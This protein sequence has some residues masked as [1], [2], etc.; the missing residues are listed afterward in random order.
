MAA[1]HRSR[2]A[3]ITTCSRTA[4]MLLCCQANLTWLCVTRRAVWPVYKN[5]VFT[6]RCPVCRF[7]APN[8]LFTVET[9]QSM[10][11]KGRS[12][13]HDKT[14]CGLQ[15][16]RVGSTNRS[17]RTKQA[18]LP[19][20]VITDRGRSP[21]KICHRSSRQRRQTRRHRQWSQVPPRHPRSLP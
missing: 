4:R 9:S 3:A 11:G 5:P 21:W 16:I 7:T 12:A 15:F 19:C 20:S 8:I 2:K 17:S 13:N 6:R 1:L 14:R 18:V 10:R